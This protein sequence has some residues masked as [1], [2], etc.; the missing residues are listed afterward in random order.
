MSAFSDYLCCTD[1]T[2]N[3]NQLKG[4]LLAVSP[5]YSSI[6]SKSGNTL[7]YAGELALFPFIA[8]KITYICFRA[9]IHEFMRL[10]RL[11]APN[12]N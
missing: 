7:F 2:K 10:R 11:N 3:K 5:I 12:A 1:W 8:P 6:Y 4:L 9:K